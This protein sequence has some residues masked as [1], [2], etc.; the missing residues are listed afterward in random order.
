MFDI[1]VLSGIKL[2]YPKYITLNFYEKKRGMH[3]RLDKR[4]DK[5]GIA[6]LGMEFFYYPNNP[7][8]E[9]HVRARV[10]YLCAN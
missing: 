7:A 6:V 2:P 10:C 8:F 9:V 5:A 3:Q 4:L 1:D